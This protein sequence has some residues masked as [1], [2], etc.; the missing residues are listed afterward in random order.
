MRVGRVASVDGM[1]TSDMRK[2][3][4]VHPPRKVVHGTH[5]RET[6]DQADSSRFRSCK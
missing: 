2:L 1:R 3:F 4:R 5:F 6:F